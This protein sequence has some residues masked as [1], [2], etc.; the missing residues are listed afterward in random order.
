MIVHRL[1]AGRVRLLRGVRTA[2]GREALTG[3]DWVVETVDTV[4]VRTTTLESG[5]GGA[6]GPGR[7]V[8]AVPAGHLA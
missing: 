2:A 6:V 4:V 1:V 7:Q 3:G 5:C 8:P